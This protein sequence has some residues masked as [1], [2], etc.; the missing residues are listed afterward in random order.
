MAHP[1]VSGAHGGQE[2]L[3]PPLLRRVS[4]RRKTLGQGGYIGKALP[5]GAAGAAHAA[6]PAMPCQAQAMLCSTD[7]ARTPTLKEGIAHDRRL[8]VREWLAADPREVAA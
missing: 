7:R 3:C 1:E 6:M 2:A 8:K 5:R 4:N